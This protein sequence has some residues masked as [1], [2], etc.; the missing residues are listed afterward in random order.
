LEN[1]PQCLLSTKGKG[2]RMGARTLK[3][4][5]KRNYDIIKRT[6]ICKTA[7]EK[8]RKCGIGGSVLSGQKNKP[9]HPEKKTE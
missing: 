3:M 2:A 9:L 6:R 5:P 1:K 4:T 8:G 7:G